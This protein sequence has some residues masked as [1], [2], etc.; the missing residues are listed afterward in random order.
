MSTTYSHTTDMAFYDFGKRRVT[1]WFPAN[2][3]PYV[4][5]DSDHGVTVRYVGVRDFD[6]FELVPCIFT[7]VAGSNH[8]VE[9]SEGYDPGSAFDWDRMRGMWEW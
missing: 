2:T 6:H 9:W 7:M 1:P 5:S 4:A 3:L 8:T